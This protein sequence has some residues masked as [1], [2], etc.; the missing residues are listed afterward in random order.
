VRASVPRR[1][2]PEPVAP[3][4]ESK[5]EQIERLSAL[6]EKGMLS[7]DEFEKAKAEVLAAGQPL[8]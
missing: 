7:E 1:A 8:R 4:Q 2:A 3:P 6:K 5:V